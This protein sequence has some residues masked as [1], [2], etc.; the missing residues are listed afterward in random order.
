MSREDR[1]GSGNLEWGFLEKNNRTYTSL[2]ISTFIMNNNN[3]NNNVHGK[4]SLSY[5]NI[6]S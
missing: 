3:N 1:G 4:M 2:S 5:L 6:L